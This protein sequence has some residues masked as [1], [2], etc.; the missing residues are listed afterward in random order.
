MTEIKTFLY[1]WLGKQKLAPSYDI[2]PSGSKHRPKFMCEVRVDGI[3]YVGIGNSTN[4][5][6]AQTNAAFDFANYLVR[7]GKLS[8]AELPSKT[9]F[10]FGPSPT[11]FNAG[12]SGDNEPSN[13]LPSGI[14]PP[15]IQIKSE[16]NNTSFS[17]ERAGPS[18]R[19]G[20][21]HDYY[22][23]KRKLEEEETFGSEEIDL[24]S[25]LH[26]N[27]TVEN[28][29]GRLHQF[30]QK[31][32]INPDY[33]YN[34]VGPEHNRSFLC[35]LIVYV[36]TLGRSLH[37]REHGSNKKNASQSCALSMIRQLF[38]LGVVEAYSGISKKKVIDEVE[39][40]PV[41]VSPDFENRLSALLQKLKLNVVQAPQAC[42]NPVS[43][44]PPKANTVVPPTVN[45]VAGV[46]PWSPPQVNWNPW[47]SC[48]IDE[49]PLANCTDEQISSDLKGAYEYAWENNT[50]L[51]EMQEE[52]TKLPIADYK[53]ELLS[54]IEANN[55]IIIRG[56]TGSGKTTQVPQYI[57]D[58]YLASARAS[59]CNIIVTQPRRISAVSVAERVADERGEELGISAGYSVRFESVLPRPHAG[60]LFCTVGVLLRKLTNGLRGVSHVIVDEIHERDI[61]TDFLLVVLRDIVVTFPGI[62][63]ILMSATIDTTIFSEYF[64]DCPVLEVHGRTHPVQEYFM[65]DCI[66]MLKFVPTPKVS[67]RKDKKSDEDDDMLPNNDENLNLQVGEKYSFQTRHSMAQLSERELSFEL[68]ETLLKYI[69]GLEVPGAVLIFLPGWNLIYSLMKHLE[70][71]PLFGGQ[72]FRILPLHSQIPREDQHKVFVPVPPGVTKIILS[73]NIAETSITINDVVFVIDSCKVK[74]KMFTS[75]NN[76]TNYATVWASQSNL[77]QRKGRA[78]RVKPGFCF[79][80]CS[81]A[82]YEKLECHLP[83]EIL[84]T[85]LHEIAL[86]IKLLKLGEI[87]QFLSKALEPPP[88]D[89][90]IEAEHLLH[91]INAL[92]RNNELTKLG[93]ILA[94]MPLEPRLGKMIILGCNFFIGD[95]MCTMAAASCFPGP[96]EMYGKRLSWKHRSFAGERFSDHVALLTCFNA[97]EEARMGG[98]DYESR[99]CEMKQVSQS[100]L[101]MTWEAKNQLKQIL[102]NEGFP[103]DCL[104]SH[105]FNN[106]GPDSKLDVAIS[107]LCIGLY[108][109]VCIY[110]EKRKVIC[111]SRPALIHKQSVNCPFG[112]KDCIFPMPFFVFGEKI[113]TRAISAKQMTMI[114]PLQL[115]MLTPCTVVAHERFVKVDDWILLEMNFQ[116][117]ANIVAL[118]QGIS[119]LIVQS[120]TDPETVM[121]PPLDE[122]EL[123]DI[124]RQFSRITAAG[125]NVNPQKALQSFRSDGGPPPPK[126]YRGRGGGGQYGRGRGGYDRGFRGRGGGRGY[127]GGYNN[128]GRGGFGRGRGRW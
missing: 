14:V 121:D 23:R 110:K 108:P 89:A 17:F 24:N 53:E 75:H 1:A 12:S 59:R 46:I 71:H 57:L 32:K 63:V 39:P 74:V 7:A 90:V 81:K 43:L 95:A 85:P 55:V 113:R 33:K 100:T 36:K 112:N 65:E 102:I 114:N 120:T 93:R 25:K 41:T 62:R 69:R 117:A 101:R 52:R 40:F 3:P 115:L 105:S 94:K 28:A 88:L 6:D 99:F 125:S 77:E 109:N 51:I 84:R 97:W 13:E 15:H 44:V 70:Q 2:Q 20:A 83:P 67:K 119:K 66:E 38:H 78:G 47:T 80:M 127:R 82:R 61:N 26:G 45:N 98:E 31:E 91:V 123:M 124:I 19:G 9:P 10:S 22:D 4:K 68:I 56:Q 21:L 58:N 8:E 35:E 72:A 103:E 42:P 16:N 111:E 48:N 76:M 34:Q 27:W 86:S 49:G 104:A 92:D 87:G 106:C 122:Q 11:D 18:Q 37:A 79:Y 116:T 126:M 54:L 29:K 60:I 107:L 73:T 96:F 30:F 118:R 64:N 5:K 128:R 50:R